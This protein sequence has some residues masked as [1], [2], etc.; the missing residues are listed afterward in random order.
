MILARHFSDGDVQM[1]L[2]VV[3]HLF[4]NYHGVWVDRVSLFVCVDQFANLYSAVT[5]MVEN[6]TR[7][8]RCEQ[9][10]L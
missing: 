7:L 9:T 8:Q 2:A 1:Q 10:N 5:R 6:R 4:A 3:G